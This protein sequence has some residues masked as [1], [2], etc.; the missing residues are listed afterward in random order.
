MRVGQDGNIVIV[1]LTPAVIRFRGPFTVDIASI[2]LPIRASKFEMMMKKGCLEMNS[3]RQVHRVIVIIVI[4][5]RVIYGNRVVVRCAI[6]LY[7]R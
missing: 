6:H 2:T 5:D 3:L 4:L 7:C 1:T